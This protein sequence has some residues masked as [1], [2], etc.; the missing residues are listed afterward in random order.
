VLLGKTKVV[1]K[2]LNPVFA[3]KQKFLISGQ[4]TP[5]ISIVI[6][7]YDA[8]SMDDPMGKI[9]IEC[10]EHVNEVVEEVSELRRIFNKHR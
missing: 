6:Y 9:D 1:K 2:K 8:M 10:L 5:T 4:Q 7:D 3:F